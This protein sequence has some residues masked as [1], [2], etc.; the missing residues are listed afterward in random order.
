MQA[1]SI[2]PS[3]PTGREALPHIDITTIKGNMTHA[4]ADRLA[5]MIRT[6]WGLRGFS[7]LD[8]RVERDRA[9][10]RAIE[11]KIPTR[12]YGYD[13]HWVVR[14]NLVGG[15]PPRRVVRDGYEHG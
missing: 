10:E 1:F 15:L 4:G 2:P 3:L 6:Y 13:P 14:S 12:D 11:S 7:M 9:V 5:K 8:V